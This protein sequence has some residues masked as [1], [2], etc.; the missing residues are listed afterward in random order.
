MEN[1]FFEAFDGMNRLAPGSEESTLKAISMYKGPKDNLK[2]LDIGCGNGIHTL[3]LARNFP[4]A[5]II[6]IDNHESFINNLNN[7]IKRNGLS[8][9][10]TGKCI[11]MFDM[12][13]EEQ[14][15]DLIWSEGAIYIAGFE[16]GLR[17]WRKLLKDDGYLICSEVSW[18]VDN[19]SDEISDF[20]DE[21]YPQIDTIKNKISQIEAAGYTYQGHFVTPSTDW[22][23]NYYIPLQANLNKMLDKYDDNDM[24]KEVVAMLQ[25]EIDLYHKY[26]DEYSYVFYVMTK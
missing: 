21:E 8:E 3:I 1:Y 2:I 9:R 17:D 16:D 19:P 10:V 23:E 15:F 26:G 20:W 24:A 5:K 25:H 12:D 4:K 14:S 18:L 6:A 13:F 22:T 11:S 7:T